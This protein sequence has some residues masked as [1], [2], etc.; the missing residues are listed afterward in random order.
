MPYRRFSSLRHGK[1]EIL[2]VYEYGGSREHMYNEK[3][4]ICMGEYADV[5]PYYVSK[6]RRVCLT[7]HDHLMRIMW[8][9]IV[10]KIVGPG[11]GH[12]VD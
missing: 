10:C 2:S 1:L 5:V 3:V 12:P 4:S 11:C 8:V 7:A 9:D 6:G